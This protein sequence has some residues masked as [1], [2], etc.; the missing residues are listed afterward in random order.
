MAPAKTKQWTLVQ[1][2]GWSISCKPDFRHAVETRSVTDAL[3]KRVLAV[4]GRVFKTYSEARHTEQE[5]NYPP[6]V[7]GIVPCCRGTFAKVKDYHEGIY[8]FP[9]GGGK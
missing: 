3:A 1:H 9:K 8:I 2:T 4:G 7:V 5:V 6:E